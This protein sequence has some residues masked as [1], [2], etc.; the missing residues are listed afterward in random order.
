MVSLHST[1]SWDSHA[2][3]PC[4]LRG[5]VYAELVSA[6]SPVTADPSVP[7]PGGP[8]P[9]LT[10]RRGEGQRSRRQHLPPGEAVCLGV[11]PAPGGPSCAPRDGGDSG[12]AMQMETVPAQVGLQGDDGLT[13]LKLHSEKISCLVRNTFLSTFSKCTN[14]H[15][16]KDIK[17]KKKNQFIHIS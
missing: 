14:I 9:G 10:A 1:C 5:S 17:G 12:T 11:P 8:L 3:K 7:P 4:I 13:S 6:R 16:S 15:R 2:P